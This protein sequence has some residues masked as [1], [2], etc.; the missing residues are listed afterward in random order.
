MEENMAHLSVF[1]LSAA[2]ARDLLY[3]TLF[4]QKDMANHGF[5]PST[6][7]TYEDPGV[8]RLRAMRDMRAGEE[9]G[10][11][12]VVVLLLLLVVVVVLLVV[13]V[14]ALVLVAMLLVLVV[15]VIFVFVVCFV[16]SREALG[17]TKLSFSVSFV[18]GVAF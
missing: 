9:V 3:Q 11:V 8:Y 7:F 1:H 13:V 12:V 15:V 10:V 18:C 6:N 17:L 16:S 2:H 5:S 14:V 4:Y